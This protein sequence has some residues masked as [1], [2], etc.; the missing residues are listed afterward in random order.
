VLNQ[1]ED[2]GDQCWGLGSECEEGLLQNGPNGS[3]VRFKSLGKGNVLTHGRERKGLKSGHPSKKQR[4]YATINATR[5]SRGD[6]E[7]RNGSIDFDDKGGVLRAAY[8]KKG[9]VQNAI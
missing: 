9:R 6:Q 2:S 1:G 3:K 8:T 5:S 4:N 7:R